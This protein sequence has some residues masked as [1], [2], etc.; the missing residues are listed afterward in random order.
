MP[1]DLKNVLIVGLG[2]AGVAAAKSIAAAL[3]S[4]HRV[5]ALSEKDFA[6]YPVVSLRAATVPGWE[7]KVTASVSAVFPVGSRHVVL[8]GTKALKL[9]ANS[10]TIDVEH[11]GFTKEIP[12]EFALICTGSTYAFPA[13]PLD[14][15]KTQVDVARTLAAFQADVAASKSILVVGGGPTGVEFSA[16]VAAQ[17]PGKS[18][19]LVHS[20]VQLF[21]TGYNKRMGVSLAGQLKTLGVKVV[22]GSRVDTKGLATGKIPEQT[23]KLATGETVAADF[24]LLAYGSTPNGALV[25]DF[26]ASLVNEK[27]AVKIKPT[28][29]VA[30]DALPHI[31]SMGDCTD[32]LEGKQAAYIA[33]HVPVVT[34][35]IVALIKNNSASLKSYKPAGPLM[36][37][38]VGP[39]GG[40][41]QLF[42]VVVG[43]WVASFVK[44]KTLMLSG[45]QSSYNVK[46]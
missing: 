16:E 1:A 7:N 33:N 20:D 18:I 46:A 12:F 27:G 37:V 10:V 32:S 8:G 9:S 40:A 43:S 6:Y 34:A 35:N 39:S 31:F 36:I 45:F 38:T 24:L 25:K 22:F 11:Q 21:G 15:D 23:F 26:D 29:Q 2:L 3:P 5:V 13:R 4:T 17:H 41:G 30:S 28:F 42:G 44:S 14:S 19:T